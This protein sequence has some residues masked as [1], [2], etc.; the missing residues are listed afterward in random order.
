MAPELVNTEDEGKSDLSANSSDVFALGMVVFE[1]S[2]AHSGRSLR[3]RL[4]PSFTFSPGK[5]R[6]QSSRLQRW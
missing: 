1:V 3:L 5:C 4:V 2:G 6:S